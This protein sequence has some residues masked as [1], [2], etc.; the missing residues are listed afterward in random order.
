MAGH[1]TH[2]MHPVDVRMLVQLGAIVEVVDP[3]PPELVAMGRALFAFR[4][5][6]A[7]LMEAVGTELDLSAP[8]ALS[9]P[10]ALS[11]VRSGWPSRMHFFEFDQVSLDVELG[12]DD[13]FCSVLGAVT[14]ADGD[15]IVEGWSVVL[16][17][18]GAS[19]TS[20]VAGDGRFD[21]P[22]VP[23]G[24]VRFHLSRGDDTP[25]VTTPWLDAR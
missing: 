3:V 12:V 5:P 7:A 20:V 23:L 10:S 25:R 6:D 14:T 15:A 16:E 13:L 9:I 4:D 19:Y 18:T 24:M 22:R 8:T 17:T 11:A 21:F 1:R 2:G